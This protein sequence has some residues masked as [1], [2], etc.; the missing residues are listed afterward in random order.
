MPLYCPYPPHISIP[1]ML[2]PHLAVAGVLEA[3]ITAGV[4][5][6]IKKTSP[7]TIYEGSP[8]KFKPLYALIIAMIC[9][10]PLGLLASGTA[11]GEWGADEINGVISGGNLLVLLQ[12]DE[13]R[14]QL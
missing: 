14:I 13:E 12:K 11:W 10:T 4:Y 1:A 5:G 2:I 8:I 6:F 7:G 9:L 3:F